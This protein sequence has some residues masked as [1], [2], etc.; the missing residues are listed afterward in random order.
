MPVKTLS[1][2]LDVTDE[3]HAV[4]DF[5]R[6]K[7]TPIENLDVLVNQLQVRAFHD[8]RS[9]FDPSAADMA[10]TL[11]GLHR[12]RE[13][14]LAKAYTG[15]ALQTA[16]SL[17]KPTQLVKH[18]LTQ[19]LA[20]REPARKLDGEWHFE[21]ASTAACRGARLRHPTLGNATPKGWREV[22]QG[23]DPKEG[24]AAYDNK[25]DADLFQ[26]T[27][28]EAPRTQPLHQMISLPQVA[29][30]EVE[31]RKRPANTLIASIYSH[32]LGVREYLNTVQLTSAIESLTDWR[33]EGLVKHLDLST[34][35]PMLGVMLKLM[36]ETQ[37]KDFDVAVAEA[38]QAAAEFE[39]M[40]DE[41][42]AQRR[43]SLVEQTR[44]ML[45]AMQSPTAQEK[46]EQQAHERKIHQL[47]IEA[48][49]TNGADPK[50]ECG[51]TL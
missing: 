32:F 11:S 4:I 15:I 30:N 2:Q 23:Y 51:L 28:L 5:V 34:E 7:W 19:A 29:H 10:V 49:G 35:H 42:K 3:I 20:L 13:E 26:G 38:T 33:A 48:Y 12:Q 45:R 40:S 41:Q 37:D 22:G 36:P 47:L 43:E 8:W 9:F 27:D 6:Q 18:L 16:I 24:M 21:N 17:D 14:A 44:E 31:H 25:A 1:K 39:R 46:A 50:N